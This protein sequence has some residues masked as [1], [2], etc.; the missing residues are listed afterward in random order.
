MNDYIK[1]K[2]EQWAMNIDEFDIGDTVV[3]LKDKSLAEITNKTSNSI[4][5]LIKAKTKDGVDCKQWYV[6]NNFNRLYEKNE[7]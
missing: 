3:E 7:E 2:Q 1:E 6:M 4:E 5:V